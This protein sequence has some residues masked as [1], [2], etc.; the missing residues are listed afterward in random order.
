M[1]FMANVHSALLSGLEALALHPSD[2]HRL[3]RFVAKKLRVLDK[4]GHYS[5]DEAGKVHRTPIIE[6]FRAWRVTPAG[7][8]MTVRRLRWFQRWVAQPELNGQLLA[9]FFTRYICDNQ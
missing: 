8:E 5:V 3:D 1:L 9:G 4:G 2:L 7:L 6:L